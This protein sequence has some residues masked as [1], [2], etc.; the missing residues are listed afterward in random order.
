[1]TSQYMTHEE[2]FELLDDLLGGDYS[3]IERL[4]RPWTGNKF[5]CEGVTVVIE[6]VPRH[7]SKVLVSFE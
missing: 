4:P 2:A 7:P 5:E 3:T 6:M 1:M